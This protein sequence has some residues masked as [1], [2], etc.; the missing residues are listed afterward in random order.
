MHVWGNPSF[1]FP[2]RL[3]R[4]LPACPRPPSGGFGAVL[5][6]PGQRGCLVGSRLVTMLAGCLGSWEL[7]GVTG[8]R[9]GWCCTA[10]SRDPAWLLPAQPVSPRGALGRFKENRPGATGPRGKKGCLS[11]AVRPQS[12]SEA[13]PLA[14]VGPGPS[15][16]PGSPELGLRLQALVPAGRPCPRLWGVLCP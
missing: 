13:S 8:D 6:H 14:A 16:R 2:E 5:L 12:W 1:C 9:G 11:Q 15:S 7:R 10:R 3:P 4:V